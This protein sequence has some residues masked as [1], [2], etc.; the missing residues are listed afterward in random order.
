[1]ATF[2]FLLESDGVSKLDLEASTDSIVGETHSVGAPTGKLSGSLSLLGV[3]FQWATVFILI[4][5][6]L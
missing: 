1:M 2:Y 5:I 4:P 6:L 3:G